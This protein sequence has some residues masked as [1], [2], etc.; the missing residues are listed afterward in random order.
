[1]YAAATAVYARATDY[2]FLLPVPR[3]F[4][5]IALAVW[6]AAFN[7]LLF[8]PVRAAIGHPKR[9]GRPS[10]AALP[11]PVPLPADAREARRPRHRG[12]RWTPQQ[13]ARHRLP[14]T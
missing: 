3:L 11:P 7:D 8:R 5:W 6:L 13:S 14:R 12:T 1:M 10:P 4:V 9:G 2:A